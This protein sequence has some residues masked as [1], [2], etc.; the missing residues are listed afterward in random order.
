MKKLLSFF[1]TAALILSLFTVPGFAAQENEEASQTIDSMD[2]DVWTSNAEKSINTTDKKQGSA[3]LEVSGADVKLVSENVNLAVE[4]GVKGKKNLE[5]WLYCED[6]SALSADST[7]VLTRNGSNSTLKLPVAKLENGWNKVTISLSF[8]SS[9]FDGIDTMEINLVTGG[10]A[11]KFMIDDIAFTPVTKVKNTAEL[12]AAVAAAKA[13]DQRYLSEAQKTHLADL[14]SR[15]E[16]TVTQRDADAIAADINGIV[17]KGALDDVITTHGR[18][19][20]V[21]DELYMSYSST[22]FSVRFY[23]TELKAQM[24]TAGGD[25]AILNIYVDR[26]TTTYE[27]DHTVTTEAG[28]RKALEDYNNICPHIQPSEAPGEYV[29]AEGLEE[30]I[31]TVTV[32]K[33]GEVSY[34]S[35]AVLTSLSTDGQLLDPP[36][37]STRKIEVIGD[38]NMTGFANLAGGGYSYTTQ[39]GTVT[40]A[41]YIANGLGADYALTA[42]SGITLTPGIADNCTEGF[43]YNTYL[44]TDYWNNGD[45]SPSGAWNGPGSNINQEDP[46]R[47]NYVTEDKLY[48]FESWDND[49]VVIHIGDND[50]DGRNGAQGSNTEFFTSYMEKFIKQ[51]RA[52]NPKAEIIVSFSISGY[53][54][55]RPVQEAAV[56]NIRAQGDTHV[57]FVAPVAGTFSSSGHPYNK[58]HYDA[59]Q[60]IIAK[61][62]EVTGWNSAV[63]E[64]YTDPT[65]D[66]VNI[67]PSESYAEPGKIVTFTLPENAEPDTVKIT[68]YGKDVEF[69]SDGNGN[70][71]FVM[72]DGAVMLHADKKEVTVVYGDIDGD[73][74]VTVTD[75]LQ[76]LQASVGKVTFDD[77]Q[78]LAA[79]VNGDGEISVTDALLVLQKSVQKIEKFPVEEKL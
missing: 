14:L 11:Q 18:A 64:V 42:R 70:Y 3:C 57:Y 62:K 53:Y 27:Y 45:A 10:K 44:Y 68:A 77:N 40:F 21:G 34:T 22:G 73:G 15:A 48:D 24:R 58:I 63:R 49:V 20:Y 60:Q 59:A 75:A 2:F 55:W 51:V 7:V 31:H 71:S 19:Y 5:M 13:A 26:D 25:S 16:A 39:D 33:R 38:S 52:V 36:A 56:N 54:D 9:K 12:E 50:H 32:L 8:V 61:I 30:G 79:D 17:E 29:L 23:G 4:G 78:R 74:T 65:V 41:G 28:A 76:V 35:R 46:G 37:R 43:M 69:T 67:V 6:V 72:P 47:F 1:L 66:E